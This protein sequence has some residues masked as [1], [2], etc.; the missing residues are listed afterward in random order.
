MGLNESPRTHLN[1]IES[2]LL[3]IT[4]FQIT[5]WFYDLKIVVRMS[6]RN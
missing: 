6:G 1:V 3:K 2:W 5:T 4:L